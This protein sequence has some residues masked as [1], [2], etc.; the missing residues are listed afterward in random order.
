M[1]QD[2]K[3]VGSM[4]LQLEN[5]V[6]TMKIINPT[7]GTLVVTSSAIANEFACN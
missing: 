2:K 7:S 4:H 6:E 5:G 1:I 3:R